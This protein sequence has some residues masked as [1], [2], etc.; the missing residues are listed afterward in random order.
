RTEFSEAEKCCAVSS[1]KRQSIFLCVFFVGKSH[2]RPP[3]HQMLSQFLRIDSRLRARKE[4]CFVAF[5]KKP[6]S[7]F[8]LRRTRFFHRQVMYKSQNGIC[9]RSIIDAAVRCKLCQRMRDTRP[10]SQAFHVE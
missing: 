10:L 6:H 3:P 9:A 7:I 4:K 5:E 8:L 2:P 1:R